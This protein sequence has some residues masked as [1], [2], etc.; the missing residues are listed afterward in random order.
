MLLALLPDLESSFETLT[1]MVK[2]LILNL[3]MVKGTRE[4]FYFFTGLI[5]YS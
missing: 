1:F 3:E 2:E 5:C 4:L